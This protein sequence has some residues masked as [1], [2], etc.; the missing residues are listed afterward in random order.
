MTQSACIKD[1]YKEETENCSILVAPTILGYMIVAQKTTD[2]EPY[3][4]GI[5]ET[6]DEALILCNFVTALH[7]V[8]NKRLE[9]NADLVSRIDDAF[10]KSI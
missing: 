5:T 3:R 9:I 10:Q 2:P 7:D 1:G 6:I 8:E 4:V